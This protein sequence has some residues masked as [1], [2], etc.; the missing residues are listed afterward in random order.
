MPGARDVYRARRRRRRV[1]PVVL[2]VLLALLAAAII[3][4]YA[5][6][7]YI[8]YDSD[9]LRVVFPIMEGD[10]PQTEPD[11]AP[12]GI[13]TEIVYEEPDYDA[14][15]SNAG[16]D[17]EPLRGRYLTADQLTESN[18]TAA[19]EQ[20]RA[21]GGNTL[22][23]QMKPA[24][25]ALSWKSSVA[26]ADAYGVNGS[27]ELAEALQAVKAQDIRLVAVVSCCVDTLLSQ[28][29]AALALKDSAGSA[30]T[31][32]SGGWLDPYNAVARGYLADLC[33]ELADMGFD[34]IAFSYLQLPFTDAE[35]SYA[36]E[37]S[38]APSRTDA[39]ASLAQALRTALAAKNVR[40]SILCSADSILQQRADQ[41]GQDLT[42]LA[43]VFDRLCVFADGGNLSTLREAIAAPDG[44]DAETRFVPFVSA[45]QESGSWVVTSG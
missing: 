36:A 29:Y 15:L 8:V 13:D 10:A 16:Q 35:F 43:K 1:W 17:L 42:M 22:V 30:Y 33:K 11:G 34:E 12:G 2:I 41:T 4:F 28:R 45:A 25:G 3:A 39:V 5:C 32:G 14:I 40:V 37:M 7:K 38:A 19:A 6:Q 24:S 31:D 21:D 18:L 9:G 23:L 26:L 44:F 27:A 20:V